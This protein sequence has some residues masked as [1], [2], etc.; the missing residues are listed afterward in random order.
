MC[1]AGLGVLALETLRAYIRCGGRGLRTY[2]RAFPAA[3]GLSRTF[4]DLGSLNGEHIV[5]DSMLDSR[6]TRRDGN[7]RY[8]YIH[9]ALLGSNPKGFPSMSSL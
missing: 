6:L 4:D 8:P 2:R 5:A 1:P 7:K 3:N 9:Q